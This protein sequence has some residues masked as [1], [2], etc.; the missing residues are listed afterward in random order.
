MTGAQPGAVRH[1]AGTGTWILYGRSTAY[2]LRLAAGSVWHVWWGPALTPEQVAELPL[3][4]RDHD[5]VL[6]EELPGE[7]GERFGPPSV[8]VSFADGTRAVEWVPA[9]H[10]IDGGHLC[11]ALADRHYPLRLEL[12][13][14]VRPDTD[15]IERWTRVHH[16]GGAEPVSVTTLDAASWTLPAHHVHRLSHVGGET[17]VEFQ[18]QRTVL[19]TGEFTLTSRRGVTRHEVNPWLMVDQGDATE[20]H[21]RVWSVALAWS[22][23]WR[24]TTRRTLAGNVTVSGGPGHGGPPWLLRPGETGETPVFAGLYSDGGFGAASRQWHAYIRGHVLPAADEVRP[25]LYNSWE[26]CGF[27]VDEPG[28]R[29]LAGIAAGL[30]VELYVVDDGWFGARTDDRAGLG[31]WWPNPARF[32][33]G[34]GPLIA[35]VHRL[36]MRFGLWVEPEMVNPDSEL[37]RRRPDWVLHMDHRRR[38][39]IR[40]QLVLNLADPEVAEWTHAWLDRLLTDHEIDYLKWDSNRAFTEA[41]WP[42]AADPG[43]L[44]LDHTRNLYA[45]IDRLRAA[46]PRLRIEACASGGGRVDLGMLGRADQTWPSDN[47]DPV[48]RIA[49]QEGYGQIYPPATMGACAGDSPNV[50]TGRAASLRFRLHVAMAGVLGLSGDLRAW[51]EAERREAADLL[52]AYRRIRPVVQHGDLYRLRPAALDRATVVQ[53]VGADAGETVV[54]AWRAVTRPREVDVPLV[55][56]RGLDPSARYRDV[57]RGVLVDGA[58]LMHAGLDLALPPGDQASVLW[59]LRRVRR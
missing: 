34:L 15:V 10:H 58:V 8:Q 25:V 53:Y 24:I 30:G 40:H 54:L 17:T 39:E 56:L 43:R 18:L 1:D 31:D 55:R 57:E 28:Q 3:P 38:T 52:A 9:G 29:A 22:G 35:E 33:D 16:T 14:R 20:E 32:P 19:R 41:G 46:H 45:I 48:D 37:Y 42:G 7:G 26:A 36:G 47:T 5:D 49:I 23:S 13:Y 44:L 21:G 6:G 50:V 12:H 51:P 27:A 4:R 59:H 2:A 11:V